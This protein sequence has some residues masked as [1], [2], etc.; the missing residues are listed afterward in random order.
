MKRLLM[1]G[2]AL[3]MMSGVAAAGPNAGGTLILHS[4]P[5]LVPSSDPTNY[6]GQSAL[7][8]CD[9]AVN[10]VA[11]GDITNSRVWHVIAAFAPA[12][13][14]RLSGIV[15]GWTYDEN[16]VVLSYSGGC[17]DFELP[18]GAWPA[19]GEGTAV[20]WNTAQT[21]ILTDVYY[22]AGYGYGT[23]CSVLQLSPHPTQGASFADDDVPSQLD[24]IAGL[25]ALGFNCAGFTP[26]PTVVIPRGACCLPNFGGCVVIEAEECAL[27]GGVY[28]GDNSGC[29]PN[30]CPP[31]PVFGACCIGEEC[32]ITTEADC[33]GA[34][35][36]PDTVCD[37]NPC[38]AVPTEETTWGSIK[39]NYR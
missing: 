11:G 38:I 6:C 39:N 16:V 30:P 9:A 37:P 8:A 28:Q 24:P 4:N 19:S 1:A 31:P 13:S 36:G 25:G 2:V 23:D 22:V 26:C 10:G 33:A 20:T 32:S 27:A 14:P 35:E 17:G 7:Q 21:S 3:A 15:F 18:S 34:W 12:S 29:D 5:G